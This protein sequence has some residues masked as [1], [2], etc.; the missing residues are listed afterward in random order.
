MTLTAG[1]ADLPE[2]AESPVDFVSYS[3][4]TTH[5]T[6][7]QRWSYRYLAGISR[8]AEDTRIELDLGSWWHAMRAADA[9]RRG[10]DLGSLVSAPH[11]ITTT[12]DGPSLVRRSD[13]R[14]DRYALDNPRGDEPPSAEEAA[15]VDVKRV[16]ALMQLWWKTLS[17]DVKD[18]WVEFCGDHPVRHLIS[19]ERRWRARWGEDL[20]HEQPVAVEAKFRRQLPGTTAILGGRVDEVYRDDRRGLVVARDYKTGKSI[21]QS[22]EEDLLD[23]QLHLY[24]WGINPLV[25]GWVGKE[26]SAVGYDRIRTSPP[27]PPAVTQSGTLSKSVTDYDLATYRAWAAGPTGHGVPYPGRKKD[28][29]QAGFYTEDPKVVEK[30]ST[31]AARAVWTD[32]TLTVLNRNVVRSHLI[33]ALDTVREAGRTKARFEGSAEA[34]RNFSRSCRWC[35]YADLCRAELMGGPGGDYDLAEM[36]LRKR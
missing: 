8:T 35:D 30:L 31:P 12:D 21:D 19:M 13:D 25:E 17:G 18:A 1:P 29:S 6:C 23:S 15:P 4:L 10:T 27:K 11:R 32:R 5:R 28:G 26:I 2:T 16:L 22:A 14:L 3:S 20:Q 33:A 24:S 36:G 7:P 9:I 34:S